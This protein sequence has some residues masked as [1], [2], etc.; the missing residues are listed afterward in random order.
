VPE[1][2]RWDTLSA[3]ASQRDLA[4]RIDDALEVIE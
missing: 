3:A 4:K 1:R 2:A